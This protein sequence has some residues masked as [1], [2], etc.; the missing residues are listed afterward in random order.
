MR[1]P[2]RLAAATILTAA[3]TAAVAA[4]PANAEPG[5]GITHRTPVTMTHRAATVVTGTAYAADYATLAVLAQVRHI[6][7]TG[8]LVPTPNARVALQRADAHGRWVTWAA[9]RTDRTGIYAAEL[10][11]TWWGVASVRWYT[12]ATATASASWS[13]PMFV[14]VPDPEGEGPLTVD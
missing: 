8:R 10:P 6:S 4:I 7:P 12:P 11:V 1:T 13:E 14:H 5:T 3:L 9:V 2:T